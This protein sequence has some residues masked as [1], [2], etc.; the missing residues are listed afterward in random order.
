[1]NKNCKP[2]TICHEYYECICDDADHVLRI[3]YL[4]D[5]EGNI[6]NGELYA[7][8]LF[9]LAGFF[10]RIWRALKYVFNFRSEPGWATWVVEVKGAKEL[11]SLLDRF[12]KRNSV[13]SIQH[14][15][16]GKTEIKC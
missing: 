16:E 13:S 9:R 15:H 11:R 2:G 8:V 6:E 12:R 10:G 3:S 5:D 4:V 7:E 1:M 14:P